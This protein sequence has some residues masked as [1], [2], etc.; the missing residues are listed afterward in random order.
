MSKRNSVSGSNSTV[1][2][3]LQAW[4]SVADSR[5]KELFAIAEAEDLAF[6]SNF[7]KTGMDARLLSSADL[8]LKKPASKGALLTSSPKRGRD[9]FFSGGG[10]KVSNGK[11]GVTNTQDISPIDSG[12]SAAHSAKKVSRRRPLLILFAHHNLQEPLGAYRAMILAERYLC[13]CSL[14]SLYLQPIRCCAG[15]VKGLRK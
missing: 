6:A 7:E 4:G 3:T 2:A 13:L 14:F 11:K 15:G 5:W 10:E 9:N 8:P 1:G 12:K